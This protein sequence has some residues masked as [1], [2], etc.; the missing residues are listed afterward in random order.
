MNLDDRGRHAAAGIRRAVGEPATTSEVDSDPF[1]R[2][3]QARRARSRNRRIANG[4]VAIAVAAVAIVIVVSTFT[5]MRRPAP[6]AATLPPG[7]ILYGEWDERVSRARWFTVRTDGTGRAD[8]HLQASCAEWFP[9]GETILITNDAEFTAD[10]PLRPAVIDADGSNLRPLDG[11]AD[12]DLNLGCGD[13]SPDGSRIVLEGFTDTDS[14]RNGIY[15]VRASDGGD[16]VRLTSGFDAYPQYSPDGGRVVFM[17]TRPGIQP[18][19]AGALFVVDAEGGR[20]DRIT[21]WGSA[22]LDQGW[23]PTGEWIAFQRPYGQLFLVRPD[24][25]DLHRV[26]VSLPQGSGARNPSW[27]PDGAWIVFSVQRAEGATVWAV[28]PD[29]SSLQRVTT[30]SGA[31]QTL[32]DWSP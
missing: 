13:V 2:F 18:D 19:G 23:S 10:T 32:P 25:T 9:D 24:G 22:F 5:P 27:S 20:P 7:T 16:L 28:R 3:E 1:E 11:T 6:A 12:R 8:L 21:P 29:G 31:D 4:V 17:R 15:S 14:E 26:D 30:S